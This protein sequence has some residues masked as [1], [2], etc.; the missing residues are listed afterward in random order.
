MTKD[1][2]DAS[3]ENIARAPDDVLKFEFARDYLLSPYWAPDR[4]SSYIDG[5][6]T[7]DIHV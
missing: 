2:N 7:T 3:I 4:T 5:T 1:E 6:V